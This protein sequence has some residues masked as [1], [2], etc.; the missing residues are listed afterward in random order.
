VLTVVDRAGGSAAPGDWL[1][2]PDPLDE[3]QRWWGW[4]TAV[5]PAAAGRPR[6]RVRWLGDGHDSVIVAPAGARVQKCPDRPGPAG[7][8]PSGCGRADRSPDGIRPRPDEE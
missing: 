2:V 3:H 7:G 6:Y 5:L 4:V 8:A 1:V